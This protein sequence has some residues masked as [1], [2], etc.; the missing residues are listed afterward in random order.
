MYTL[1][2]VDIV[3]VLYL[4]KVIFIYVMVYLYNFHIF[5]WLYIIHRKIC[6][7][8]H[9]SMQTVPEHPHKCDESD[10]SF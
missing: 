10:G 8:R 2:Y 5:V 3:L 4:Q 6:C 7:L 9:A 1:L